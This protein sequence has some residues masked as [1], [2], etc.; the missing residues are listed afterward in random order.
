MS[1]A[2]TKA[3][4]LSYVSQ[5]AEA[6][7]RIAEALRA[8]GIVVWLDQDELT[9]GDARAEATDHGNSCRRLWCSGLWSSRGACSALWRSSWMAA[10]LRFWP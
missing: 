8:A 6:V 3:V 2:E 1:A 10:S 5:D 9:G 7:E 4:F